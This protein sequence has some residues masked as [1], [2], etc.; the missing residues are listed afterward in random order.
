MTQLIVQSIVLMAKIQ[1]DSW[2]KRQLFFVVTIFYI[3]YDINLFFSRFVIQGV[4]LLKVY[5]LFKV[6]IFLFNSS[7]RSFLNAMKTMG[8][9]AGF[10]NINSQEISSKSG[11]RLHKSK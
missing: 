10:N 6:A 4:S 2:V 5:K 9:I 3:I 1:C 11:D 7:L 8:F